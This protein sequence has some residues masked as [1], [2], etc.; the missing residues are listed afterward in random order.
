MNTARCIALS[1]HRN[2]FFSTKPHMISKIMGQTMDLSIMAKYPESASVFADTSIYKNGNLNGVWLNAMLANN[3]PVIHLLLEN[4]PEGLDI[5][6][7]IECRNYVVVKKMAK[8]EMESILDRA[9]LIGDLSMVAMLLDHPCFS[10]KWAHKVIIDYAAREGH[11]QIIIFLMEVFNLRCSTD[12]IDWAATNGHLSTV[13]YLHETG[14][15]C[16]TEA[17]RGAAA[18]GQIR[19]LS[20]LLE[21]GAGFMMDAV[22]DAFYNKQ[23]TCCNI[24]CNFIINNGLQLVDGLIVS[25]IF[26]NRDEKIASLIKYICV[27]FVRDYNLIDHLLDFA[28]ECNNIAVAEMLIDN[29]MAQTCELV[30]YISLM[31]N[32]HWEIYKKIQ[33]SSIF[34]VE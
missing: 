8:P 33:N 14:H 25:L 2:S 1:L 11:K 9:I 3:W 21:N 10:D 29:S 17:I 28:I 19:T 15:T 13:K 16:T 30:N 18:N 27:H 7:A 6:D 24:L 34:I 22:I 12:A 31:E 5:M 20:Y 23:I 4:Y 32:Q 26:H